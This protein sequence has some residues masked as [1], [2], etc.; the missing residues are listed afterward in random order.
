MSIQ[1]GSEGTGDIVELPTTGTFYS[2][3]V[4]TY[5]WWTIPR[6]NYISYTLSPVGVW[7]L[8]WANAV[9]IACNLAMRSSVS[10]PAPQQN[11]APCI[12]FFDRV[13]TKSMNIIT[14]WIL[15][16]TLGSTNECFLINNV[17]MVVFSNDLNIVNLCRVFRQHFR[18]MV[19]EFL[20]CSDTKI[21]NDIVNSHFYNVS[22]FECKE[23]I[24]FTYWQLW[25]ARLW[26]WATQRPC[27]RCWR[28]A[29]SRGD[30]DAGWHECLAMVQ[31]DCCSVC[32]AATGSRIQEGYC[33]SAGCCCCCCCCLWLLSVL[34]AAVTSWDV[35]W[36]TVSASTCVSS[37]CCWHWTAVMAEEHRRQAA[38][39]TKGFQTI[40]NLYHNL[41]PKA[42]RN[43]LL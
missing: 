6:W 11:H 41:T 34:V 33:P 39:K 7:L 20:I 10:I 14:W 25:E 21:P 29:C 40:S 42:I 31:P 37:C 8:L 5:C 16:R 27:Q 26:T 18:R 23:G 36:P 24:R 38:H 22:W 32:L 19:I 43:K 3:G 13:P 2:M 9:T 1:K 35:L 4:Y 15:W 12:I 17:Q 30:E 28:L